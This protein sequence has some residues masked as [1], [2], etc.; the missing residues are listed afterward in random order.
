MIP[1]AAPAADEMEKLGIEEAATG[2]DRRYV[3]KDGLVHCPGRREGAAR[4]SQITHRLAR[5]GPAAI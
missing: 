3:G 1:A 4:L 2:I 5:P